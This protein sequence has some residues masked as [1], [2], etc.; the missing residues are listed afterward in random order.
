MVHFPPTLLFQV[1]PRY[2]GLEFC[3]EGAY[4][5]VV[6][7]TDRLTGTKVAIKKM[8]PFEHQTYCQRTLREVKILTRF[9]HENIIDLKDII[10]D[11]SVDKLKVRQQHA[12]T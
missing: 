12:N 7:A 4:G 10:C 2:H 3:G 8:T 9:R 1:G 5:V 6:S 11:N